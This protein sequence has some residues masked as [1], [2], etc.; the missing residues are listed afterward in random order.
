MT[1]HS[2]FNFFTGAPHLFW[3]ILLTCFTVSC[4]RHTLIKRWG[5]AI[6]YHGLLCL[7]FGVLALGGGGVQNSDY[8]DLKILRQLEKDNQLA[9]AEKQ[10]HAY[11]LYSAFG[12]LFDNLDAF[13]AYIAQHDPGVDRLEAVFIGWL[14]AS[15]CDL[16]F[17]IACLLRYLLRRLFQT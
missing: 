17:A 7:L 14:L 13:Q 8:R 5:V 16:A 1:I 2:L 10:P 11:N 9:E 3:T 4:V 15:V 6:C 12:F